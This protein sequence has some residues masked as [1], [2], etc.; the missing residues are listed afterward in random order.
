MVWFTFP[1]SLKP[2]DRYG[3]FLGYALSTIDRRGGRTRMIR[4]FGSV[5][6]RYGH[7]ESDY[8][9]GS[10]SHLNPQRQSI[11]VWGKSMN[12]KIA[13]RDESH[14]FLKYYNICE[15]SIFTAGNA[16]RREQLSPLNQSNVEMERC[17]IHSSIL[18]SSVQRTVSRAK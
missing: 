3:S 5:R 4:L 16:L 9:E 10:D 8:G 12:D 17:E 6:Q 18:C 15:S 13:C 1:L 7:R 2:S 14:S 11:I